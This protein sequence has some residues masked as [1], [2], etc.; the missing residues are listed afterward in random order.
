M[1]LIP[2]MHNGL[3][4]SILKCLQAQVVLTYAI[5]TL[6]LTVVNGKSPIWTGVSVAAEKKV[7]L[8]T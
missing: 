2:D 4:C 1:N 8:Q 5:P 3:L 6:G 7:Y